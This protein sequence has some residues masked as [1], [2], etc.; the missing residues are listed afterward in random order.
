MPTLLSSAKSGGCRPVPASAS[1][2]SVR[3]HPRTIRSDPRP[4]PRFV[5]VGLGH[6]RQKAGFN[7]SRGVPDT[8]LPIL[9]AIIHSAP[10]AAQPRA[11]TIAG[12]FVSGHRGRGACL[13]HGVGWRRDAPD[14]IRS[15]HHSMEAGHRHPSPAERRGVGGRVR[16]IQANPAIRKLNPDMTLNGFKPSSGGSGPIACWPA[17]SA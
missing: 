3:P 13:P 6:L 4:V 17:S 8:G 10:A 9:M 14:R 11:L 16:P 7:S 1:P 2:N 5:H 15:F 12:P